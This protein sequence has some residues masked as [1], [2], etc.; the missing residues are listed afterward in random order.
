VVAVIDSES[1]DGRHA[2]RERNR[3][4]VLD[5]VIELFATNTLIP[6]VDEVAKRSGLSLRSVY[7]YYEDLGAL[8]HAAIERSMENAAPLLHIEDIGTGPLDVRVD[9][10]VDCRVRLY[11]RTASSFRATIHHSSHNKPMADALVTARRALRGQLERQFEPELGLLDPVPRLRLVRAA[12]VLTRF[13]AIE[14]LRIGDGLTKAE[15]KA[16]LASGLRA[17]LSR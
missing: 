2:R 13:E 10:F 1:V 16:V 15:T 7:R 6:S 14:A 3:I 8:L 17:L 9:A 5:A 4:A 12:D 11:E